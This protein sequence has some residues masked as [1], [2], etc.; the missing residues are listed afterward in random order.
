MKLSIIIPVYNEGHTL[1]TL[2]GRVRNATLTYETEII[3]VD[4]FSQDN[5]RD[6]ILDTLAHTPN[7][8][9]VLKNVNRG[10][11]AAIREALRYTT[12]DY[13]LI[14]DADLEYSPEDYPQLLTPIESGKATVVFGS[15]FLSNNTVGMNVLFR[16]GNKFL[17]WW[18]NFLYGSRITDMETCF[19]VIPSQLL[20]SIP[21]SGNRFDFE[22][23]V[24]AKLLV[25]GIKITE[26]PI[27]YNGRNKEEGKKIGVW[28]GIVAAAS[29]LK[30]KINNTSGE[31][32]NETTVI[33]GLQ[34]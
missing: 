17:T 7:L 15:R 9:A 10:K 27:S 20:K 6:V 32:V 1:P 8:V 22:P 28:D 23:E 16:W 19:K 24:T 25:R 18:T 14:Q 4:D 13:V 29:L 33:R 11:G 21:L 34:Q 31:S 2:L 30:Y 5:S 3:I 12:G 26:V